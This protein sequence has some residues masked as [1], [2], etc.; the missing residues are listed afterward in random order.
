M[1]ENTNKAIAYNTIILY[2]R[3][4]I[5]LVFGLLTT[6]YAL[7][8]LGVID[9]GL[10]SVVGSIIVFINIVNTTMLGFLAAKTGVVSLD[11]LLKTINDT[12]KGKV[13]SVNKEA[14]EFIYNKYAN[15]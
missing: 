7:R 4:G 5:T 9:F 3:L 11:S 10:T 12:F 6:R 14:T 2:I 1:Q 8:A 13:A 15:A